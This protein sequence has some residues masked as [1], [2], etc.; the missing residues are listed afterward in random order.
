MRHKFVGL[1]VFLFISGF[2]G[3]GGGSR[4]SSH[5]RNIVTSQFKVHYHTS[6]FTGTEAREAARKLTQV[7]AEVDS[8]LARVYEV[9]DVN[10]N[11][12]QVE[13]TRSPRQTPEGVI[14]RG[15]CRST[16]PVTCFTVWDGNLSYWAGEMESVFRLQAFGYDKVYVRTVP[17]PEKYRAGKKCINKYMKVKGED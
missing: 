3:C 10:L 15:E 13:I 8:C 16:D 5:Y 6:S 7:A 4:H 2:G 12:R 11:I 9:D 17:S 1:V 14:K